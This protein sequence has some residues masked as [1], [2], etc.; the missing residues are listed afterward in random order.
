MAINGICSGSSF[1]R[2]SSLQLFSYS[3]LTGLVLRMHFCLPSG[4]SFPTFSQ[5]FPCQRIPRTL[6]LRGWPLW[7]A[8]SSLEPPSCS[9]TQ[10]PQPTSNRLR[11]L[12]THPT[13]FHPSCPHSQVWLSIPLQGFILP[14]ACPIMSTKLVCVTSFGYPSM[15]SPLTLFVAGHPDLASAIA[16]TPWIHMANMPGNVLEQTRHLFIMPWC[17][18]LAIYSTKQHPINL[19]MVYTPNLTTSSGSPPAYS[20]LISR[21]TFG[22]L[23]LPYSV[24]NMAVFTLH[25]EWLPL[26]SP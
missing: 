16:A 18:P 5:S 17:M 2:S 4:P 10:P 11:S 8:S 13:S 7:I 19:Q 15:T 1:T 25:H 23:T 20:N 9:M 3:S 21:P 12:P 26:M 6:F 24:L 22:Q 14:T